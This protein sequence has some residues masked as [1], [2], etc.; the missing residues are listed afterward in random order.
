MKTSNIENESSRTFYFKVFGEYAL[1][2]DPV[3][4][5][6]GERISYAV[7]TAQ[8]LKGIIDACYFKPSFENEVQ[9]VK[10]V[11]PIKLVSRGYRALYDSLAPGLNYITALENLVY[12]VK[13]RFSWNLS[14]PDLAKDRIMKKHEAIME[15]SLKKGGRRDVFLGSREFLGYVEYI[16]EEEYLSEK[17]AYF[18]STLD[19]GNMFHSFRYPKFKEDKFESLFTHIIMQDGIIKFKKQE[20]CEIRN[21]LSTYTYKGNRAIV[22][23][24]EELKE[25]EGR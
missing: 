22:S 24:D 11:N 23:V 1:W 25:Y 21:E 2:T 8:A 20:E 6:G 15:R 9:E 14:R 10:V 13:F 3:S 5:G 12:L 17:T 19:F 18:G 4:K 16:T 7:P